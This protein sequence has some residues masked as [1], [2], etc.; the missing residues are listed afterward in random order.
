MPKCGECRYWSAVQWV[1]LHPEDKDSDTAMCLRH[2]PGPSLRV[3]TEHVSRPDG[4]WPWVRGREWC[5]DFV[6]YVKDQD[7]TV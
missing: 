3:T 6:A 4:V 1:P 2:A 7:P 5:G